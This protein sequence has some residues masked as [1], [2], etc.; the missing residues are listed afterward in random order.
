MPEQ[1]IPPWVL[2]A[3]IIEQIRRRKEE[4]PPEQP[5]IRPEIPVPSSGEEKP[6]DKGE[7]GGVVE[8]D[9]RV[10]DTV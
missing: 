7:E 8:I 4:Q 6:D 9:D 3:H 5:G 2:P 10:D 1:K